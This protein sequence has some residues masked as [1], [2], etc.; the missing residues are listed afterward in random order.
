MKYS[1][2]INREN[3]KEIDG[4]IYFFHRL[5]EMLFDYTVDL[6]KMPLLNTY[7]LIKEF[8]D[9]HK[10]MANGE[11]KEYQLNVVF[12]ELIE[13]LKSDIVLKECWGQ[14]KVDRIVG[15][16]GSSSNQAKC[17]TI[18]YLNSLFGN[19]KYYN[20]CVQVI[21]KYVAQP[22]K[23]QKI[24]AALRCFLPELISLGYN[25]NFVYNT[26]KKTLSREVIVESSAS[27]FIKI[28]DFK[29]EKYRVYFCVSSMAK[30]YEEIL[31]NRLNVHFEDDGNF[32]RFKKDNNKIIIYFDEIYALCP[33][34]AAT[35]AYE[36]LDLFF[37][38]YKFVSDQKSFSM[39]QRAMVV[40]EN[41]GFIFLPIQSLTYN[42]INRIDYDEIGAQSDMLITGLLINAKS[43]YYLLSKSLEM[44]NTALAIPDLKS[45]FL[46]F[47][48]S[49]EVLCK[50]VNAESKLESVLKV[51]IPILK[52]DYLISI[53]QDID[54]S[55]KLNMTKEDYEW[56]LQQ[57][58][59][60]G[61]SKKKLFYMIFL[62]KYEELRG[63]LNDKLTYYPVLRTR[64]SL[65]SKM[66][67]TQLLNDF[68]NKYVQRVK[69][70][71]Y[72]MYRAR[73]AIVHS[74]EIPKN[75]KYLGEHL[76]SYV[77][78]TL[79]EFVVKLSGEIP[80]KSIEDILVDVR[81]ALLR[82][83]SVLDKNQPI[84]DKILN[85]IIHPE[86]GHTMDCE[87]HLSD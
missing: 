38:F 43:E 75:I 10:R 30:K 67:S 18:K 85:M 72:R 11:V 42:I 22:K 46:N 2:P 19:G 65:L 14:E 21:N 87:E 5:E 55:L 20:W 27:N 70:H 73:N 60:Q 41:D 56:L 9:V 31:K 54:N 50:N 77:D 45:G 3:L 32:A 29:R 39:K 80:F 37:S 36:R 62:S 23:K 81:F 16:F 76:H 1:V 8:C 68:I 58:E 17:D 74:G 49:I 66:N 84:D 40:D 78:S 64:I 47:W 53:I 24:E 26:L 6:Y 25:P 71:I 63:K 83:E 15:S 82:L 61:C 4:V 52:K 34:S 13:S 79:G 35:I 7:R 59:E 12:D 44:H 69:W 48:S 57:I 28:F 51:V 33:N 86:I